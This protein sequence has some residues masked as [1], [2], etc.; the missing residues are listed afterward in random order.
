[1]SPCLP[2][3]LNVDEVGAMSATRFAG[4]SCVTASMDQVNVRRPVPVG[5][6]AL[7][8]AFVYDAGRTS[9]R[10]RVTVHREDPET[11]ERELT[12]ESYMVFVAIDE[13]REPTRVPELAVSTDEGERLR[14]E[15]RAGENDS[16]R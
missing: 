6:I 1:M 15:A 16:A 10:V 2:L 14:G 7:A 9:V 11:A 4:S 5:N 8:E 12:T 13:E 3:S